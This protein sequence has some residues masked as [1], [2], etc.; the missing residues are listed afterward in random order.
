MIFSM[1]NG[2]SVLLR[3]PLP[4]CSWQPG[5][6]KV[7]HTHPLALARTQRHKS[8]PCLPEGAAW[9][10]TCDRYTVLESIVMR[11]IQVL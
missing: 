3:S 4:S 1:S 6:S 5:I 2:P 10:K 8:D 9:S 7:T 11:A